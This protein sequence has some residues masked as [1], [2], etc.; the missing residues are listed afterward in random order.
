MLYQ[1][2]YL[3]GQS[4][5][6]GEFKRGSFFTPQP[7]KF[8]ELAYK[9][10]EVGIVVLTVKPSLMPSPKRS[11]QQKVEEHGT[12]AGLET[13]TPDNLVVSGTQ[14][15]FQENVVLEQREI[16]WNAKKCFTEMDEDGDLKNGIRVEVN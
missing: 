12:R 16:R 1:E 8:R 3:V 10:R 2:I 15:V 9:R 5:N 7:L 14:L 4:C 11:F 6:M 13:H